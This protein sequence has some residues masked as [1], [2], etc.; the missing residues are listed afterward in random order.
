MSEYPCVS[1]V[2][3][4]AGVTKRI[5]RAERREREGGRDK[6]RELRE[7][8][9]VPLNISS[10]IDGPQ[11]ITLL[12]LPIFVEFLQLYYGLINYLAK[13]GLNQQSVA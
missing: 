9:G 12:L 2:R 7:I 13:F 6:P 1:P 4:A 8:R 11:I 5:L 3:S 10:W